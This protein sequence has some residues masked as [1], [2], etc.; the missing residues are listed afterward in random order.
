MSMADTAIVGHMGSEIYIAAIAVGGSLFNLLYWSFGFLRMGTSGMTAQ[1]FGCK[2]ESEQVRI[3]LR[4][5]FVAF[6]TGIAMIALQVPLITFMI[7]FMNVTGDTSEL[8]KIYCTTCIY[9]AP[10]MLG[11]Y[12]LSGWF[13]GRQNTRR[14]MFIS[15]FVNVV[16]IV[17]SLMFVYVFDMSLFGVAFGTLIAQWA[18]FVAGIAFIVSDKLKL[19]TDIIKSVMEIKSLKRFFSINADIFFRTLCMIAVTLWFTRCGAMQGEVMLSVN[20]I[21]MQFFII[22]SYFADGFAYSGEALAGKY[23]GAKDAKH[24]SLTVSSLFRWGG[25]TALIFTMVYTLFGNTFLSLLCDNDAVLTA[26]GP[27]IL[28]ICAIP[29]AGFSAFIWDGVFIGLTRTR[30]MLLSMIIAMCVFFALWYFFF[31]T[32]GNNALWLAFISYLAIRGGVLWL[33][34]HKT[35]EAKE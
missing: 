7:D 28:W 17:L 19:N 9:G 22:F 16:N 33:V 24:L 10:A 6:V 29:A 3:L 27:Y 20:A 11:T 23:W 15:I 30:S 18:G 35:I 31:P 2:D 1:A 4:A 26:S 5:L 21:L 12:A 13:I 32:F 25:T 8:V 34:Y 14:P